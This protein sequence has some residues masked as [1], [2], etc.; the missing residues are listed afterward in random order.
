[1]VSSPKWEENKKTALERL[2][3]MGEQHDND[4]LSGWERVG[5]QDNEESCIYFYEHRTKGLDGCG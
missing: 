4:A 2:L 1:M 5:H 3:G